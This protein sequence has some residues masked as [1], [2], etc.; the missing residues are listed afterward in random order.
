MIPLPSSCE[1]C[2]FY[3]YRFDPYNSFTPDYVVPG[4]K[5]FFLAQ[6]PGANEAEGKQFIRRRFHGGGKYSDE[7]QEVTPQPLI[8]K[9]GQDFNRK[10]L[11][12][13]GLKR[14]E[15]SVGN[16]IRCR[17]GRAL[18]LKADDLPTVTATMRLEKSKADI[19]NALKHC[20]ATH[21]HIPESV[22]VVVAMGRHAMFQ[23]TGLAK[24]QDEYKKKQG[25]LESWRGYG[26]EVSDYNTICTVGTSRYHTLRSRSE[27][28][29]EGERET[30]KVDEGVYSEGREGGFNI[31]KKIVF[32]TMHIAA[33]NY[34]DNK[35]YTHATYQDFH[36]LGML[37]RGEWPGPIPKWSN[38]APSEWPS[39]ASFDTEYN[40]DTREL[41]RWSMCDRDYNLYCVEHD[42]WGDNVIPVQQGSTVLIQNALADISYLSNLVDMRVV[43]VEDLMLAHSVLWPGEPHNLNY[44]NSIYGTLNRYKHLPEDEPE[45]YSAF[46]SYE[47]MQEWKGYFIPEFKRDKL[48]WQVYQKYRLPLI[49]IIDKA[50]QSGAL[51]DTSRLDDVKLILMARLEEYKKRA[52]ELTGDD[53]F[54]LGGSKRLREE[55]YG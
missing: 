43:K 21:L 25:V 49:P 7:S 10:F 39:Y 45:A 5:V 48:S 15:V 31:E 46:D 34:R 16:A 8:G 36:K 20:K 40:P 55:L 17:P 3:Q 13:S 11:P 23:M 33:L 1:G 50:Q 30:R 19:V 24:D 14:S 4:S 12:E 47:P 26:V 22:N 29:E 38:T 2:P 42:S 35:K 6:N 51:L 41:Y 18:G 9:T 53:T 37:L 28:Y 54:Q 44:I 52:M 27:G 32:F